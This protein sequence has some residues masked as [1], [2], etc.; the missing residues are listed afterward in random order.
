MN[1]GD[2]FSELKFR[3]WLQQSLVRNPNLQPLAEDL[4]SYTTE[5]FTGWVQD[6]LT[7]IVVEGKSEADAF[8]PG[9]RDRGGLV[10]SRRAVQ[11][12]SFSDEL[13]AKN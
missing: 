4:Q 7:Q 2:D 1:S 11:R 8:S 5:K 6:G 9:E 3:E 10:W 12:R 13:T